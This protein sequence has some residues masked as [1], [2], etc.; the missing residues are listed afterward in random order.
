MLCKGEDADLDTEEKPAAKAKPN[1]ILDSVSIAAFDLDGRIFRTLW[2]SLTRTPDVALAGAKGDFSRYLSPIRVFVAL[3]SFQFVVASLFGTPLAGSLDQLTVSLEPEAVEA[4]L[5]TGRSATG[6][7]PTAAEVN[8][9]IESWGAMLLWPITIVTALPYL[10]LKLYRPG[11]PLWGHVQFFLT[12][13]NASFVV[14]IATI[15][16]LLLGLGWFS[17]GIGFAMIVYYFC[18]GRIIVRFYSHSAGGAA[19]RLLGL[20]LIMPV[21][22]LMTGIGQILGTSLTLD[23]NYDLSLVQL[24]APD[25]E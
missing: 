8:Q 19:L 18:T 2:H 23:M 14:M 11:V 24:Y 13:T 1:D 20:F 22:L 5:A 21:T 7:I 3:F 25:L 12:A 17:L 4:W 9:T 16:L 6:E 10:L 15:P